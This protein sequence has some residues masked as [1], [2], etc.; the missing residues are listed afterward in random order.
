MV[1]V[2]LQAGAVGVAVLLF[3]LGWIAP[4]PSMDRADRE[5]AYLRQALADERAA[6]E[7]ERE[8]Y[9][10]ES[11]GANAA[12]LEA[13]KTTVHLLQD[14]RERNQPEARR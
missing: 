8:T 9:R 10:L 6:R 2:L 5:I 1:D 11:A 7:A 14:L 13:A 12:A 4:K 3:V